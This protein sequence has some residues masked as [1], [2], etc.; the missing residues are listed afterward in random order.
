MT[1]LSFVNTKLAIET[2]LAQIFIV[3]AVVHLVFFRDQYQFVKKFLGKYGLLFAG[4]TALVATLG[5]LFYSEYAGYAPCT[6]CWY[7]RIFMYPEVVLLGIAFFKKDKGIINYS[8]VMSCMG[9][10][11]AGYHYLMQLG[12]VGAFSC[13]AVGY[14]LSCSKIFLMEFGYVTLPLMSLTA[15]LLII[16]F[17]IFSKVHPVK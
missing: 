8:L 7:Q 1:L 12:I 11:I 4:L 14:S 15:F 3:L 10:L 5:S 6:F 9:A 13:S 2:I 16:V 17:L